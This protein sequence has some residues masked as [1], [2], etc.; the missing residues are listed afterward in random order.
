MAASRRA[1]EAPA[2][3]GARAMAGTS[4]ARKCRAGRR[5]RLV[6]LLGEMGAASIETPQSC[7]DPERANDGIAGRAR[8]NT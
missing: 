1:T 2:P 3:S 8:I 5:P 7:V 6:A 4:F